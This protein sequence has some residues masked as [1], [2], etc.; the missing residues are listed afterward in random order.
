MQALWKSVI[1]MGIAKFEV[2][3]REVQASG[4]SA[5]DIGNYQLRS[6]DGTVVDRGNYMVL[7]KRVGGK[8]LMHRD[9]WTTS[10][11]APK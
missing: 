6:T 3:V 7:W 1:D 4:D 11:P 5:T 10:M 9:I 2:S 8:W